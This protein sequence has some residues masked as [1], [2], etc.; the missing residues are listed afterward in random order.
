MDPVLPSRHTWSQRT[1]KMV[2]IILSWFGRIWV[3]AAV[4]GLLNVCYALPPDLA[5]DWLYNN[6]WV[7]VAPVAIPP[8]D[9]WWIVAVIV[10]L[11]G[12]GAVILGDKLR[13]RRAER[14]LRLVFW[15]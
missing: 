10:S 6:G 13:K 8:D 5:D 15:R 1:C 9:V 4:V 11:P 3:A 2:G 7:P 14:A 12:L